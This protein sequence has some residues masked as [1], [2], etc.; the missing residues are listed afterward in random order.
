MR[1][2][3]A[4]LLS[5][6]DLIATL[7]LI[8]WPV[9]AGSPAAPKSHPTAPR[10]SVTA[11]L[12]SVLPSI[13]PSQ[14]HAPAKES[15]GF[16]APSGA[17]VNLTEID[18]SI[19]LDIRYA[20]PHNFV[21]RRIQGYLAPKCLLTRQAADALKKIQSELRKEN[22]TLRI[23]DCY[24][25]HKAVQDFLAWFKEPDHSQ[26]KEIYYPHIEK[27]TLF[28]D[29]Y[30]SS[31]SAHS[32]GSTVDITVDGLDMGTPFDFFDPLSHTLTTG[33]SPLQRENR[34]YLKR[35]MEKA[36]FKN[37]PTEWWHYTLVSEP[38]S[39]DSFDFDIR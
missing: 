4:S 24:R 38:F 9:F 35:K 16:L 19:L 10:S 1:L 34:Q 13:R 20:T 30:L 18:P 28:R 21:G 29:S 22:Q 26:Q 6:I 15:D 8:Q 37:L 12:P 17:F 23:Y 5:I 25:P 33:I 11:T 27:E 3:K 7:A 32:R 39:E 2:L 31:K 36:G 14:L